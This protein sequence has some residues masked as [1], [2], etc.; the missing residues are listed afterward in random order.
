MGR[1]M[2]ES[3]GISRDPEEWVQWMKRQ[4]PELFED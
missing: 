3:D 2:P 4:R 1:G